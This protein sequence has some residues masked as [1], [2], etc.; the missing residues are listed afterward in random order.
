MCPESKDKDCAVTS[1][2]VSRSAQGTVVQFALMNQ[3]AFCAAFILLRHQTRRPA[4]T[5]TAR[6]GRVLGTRRVLGRSVKIRPLADGSGNAP[7]NVFFLWC[8]AFA[9]VPGWRELHGTRISTP[10]TVESS[11][12][13]DIFPSSIRRI[14][15]VFRGTENWNFQRCRHTRGIK[16]NYVAV[17]SMHKTCV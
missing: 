3:Q 15:A 5:A 2:R 4:A 9:G 17:I 1:H 16:K 8:Q 14:R 6:P 7:A 11:S 12:S 13:N 10:G